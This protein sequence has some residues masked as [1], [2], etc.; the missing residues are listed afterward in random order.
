M[1]ALAVALLAVALWTMPAQAQPGFIRDFDAACVQHHPCDWAIHGIL[2]TA[3]TLTLAAVTPLKASEARWILIGYYVQR[4]IRQLVRWGPGTRDASKIAPLPLWLDSIFDL[5]GV[6][7]AAFV[8]VPKLNT[9]S[10]WRRGK[11]RAEVSIGPGLLMV[12]LRH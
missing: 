9:P 10:L 1:R 7:V 6:A 8:L 11:M 5:G 4:D 2:T 12:S 3:G